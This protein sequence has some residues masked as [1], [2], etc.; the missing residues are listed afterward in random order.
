MHVLIST[1]LTSCHS[2][3]LALWYEMHP[4]HTCLS[5]STHLGSGELHVLGDPGAAAA[6]PLLLALGEYAAPIFGDPA[7]RAPP[8]QDMRPDTSGSC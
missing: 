2:L 7:G 4:Q 1:A 3:T 5:C 6:A 8:S